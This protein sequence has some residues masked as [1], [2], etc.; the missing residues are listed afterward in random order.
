MRISNRIYFQFHS[1]PSFAK[2]N[3]PLGPAFRLSAPTAANGRSETRQY[4]RI[5]T[6]ASVKCAA[7]P[8]ERRCTCEEM[9]HQHSLHPQKAA[10]SRIPAIYIRSDSDSVSK[11]LRARIGFADHLLS[12][13][14]QVCL[15]RPEKTRCQKLHTLL[16]ILNAVSAQKRMHAFC[17]DS[18]ICSCIL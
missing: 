10:L 2:D 12:M 11:M 16:S 17:T 13:V 7:L 15:K 6:T 8:N 3:R 14:Y 1:R 4:R 18:C 5:R 9:L